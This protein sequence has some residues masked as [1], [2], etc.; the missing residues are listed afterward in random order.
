MKKTILRQFAQ[1]TF[2]TQ[3]DLARRRYQHALHN[4]WR[5]L[6]YLIEMLIYSCENMSKLRT[7]APF[8]GRARLQPILAILCCSSGKHP[9]P[10]RPL[11]A[12]SS[13]HFQ[14]VVLFPPIVMTLNKA[15]GMT[16]RVSRKASTLCCLCWNQVLIL[17]NRTTLPHK[18]LYK[19]V[20]VFHRVWQPIAR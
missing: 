10:F 9:L 13:A 5:H 16:L 17:T 20:Q 12:T 7:S 19:V 15:N 14:T 8:F 6:K 2:S 18:V 11:R 1:A 4:L 3:M